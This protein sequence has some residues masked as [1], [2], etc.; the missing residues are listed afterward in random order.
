MLSCRCIVLVPGQNRIVGGNRFVY[1][2]VA[3]TV[4]L[5]VVRCGDQRPRRQTG[6]QAGRRADGQAG[7]RA[8]GQ[9][10]RRAGG[11]TDTRTHG[12]MSTRIDRDSDRDSD[13]D[14]D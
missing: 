11:H 5:V 1:L 8:G 4:C 2:S 12:H 3:V 9:A 10:G 14:T 6:R 7:R 13:R